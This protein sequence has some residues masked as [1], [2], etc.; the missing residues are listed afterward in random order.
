MAN[1]GRGGGISARLKT[2]LENV[3]EERSR[4][5]L[6]EEQVTV[7]VKNTTDATATPCQ[8]LNFCVC[9]EPGQSALFMHNNF[10]ALWK[11]FIRRPSRKKEDKGQGKGK[12]KG[13]D[14]KK[15]P[16]MP[17]PF[18]RKL[19]DGA[20]LVFC[21]RVHEP[22]SF[23]AQS[24]DVVWDSIAALIFHG[25]NDPGAAVV[26]HWV[27]VGYM[28]FS[29][30]RFCGC[31]LHRCEGPVAAAEEAK[32]GFIHLQLQEEDHDF[33]HCLEFFATLD[34]ELSWTVKAFQ[35]VSNT[36]T[37]ALMIPHFVEVVELKP[38][39]KECPE[40]ILFWK[41][42]HVES[43]LRKTKRAKQ[44]S[45]GPRRGGGGGG[46]AGRARA[47]VPGR[48]R[49]RGRSRG[50]AAPSVLALE[51]R[52]QDHDDQ[53]ADDDEPADDPLFVAEADSGDEDTSDSED[54]ELKIADLLIEH[55]IATG[56]VPLDEESKPKLASPGPSGQPAGNDEEEEPE[57]ASSSG[58]QAAASSS[59]A[60]PAASDDLA[61]RLR[62]APDPEDTRAPAASRKEVVSRL[63]RED[64]IT[65]PGYGEITYYS[66]SKTLVATCTNPSHQNER[67]CKK[68]KTVKASAAPG[69][70]GQGRPLGLLMSWVTT[71]EKHDDQWSHVHFGELE[72]TLAQRKSARAEFFKLR[73]AERF[74][75]YE[76]AQ[77]ANEE[78]EPN[79][80]P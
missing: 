46:R 62:A 14:G 70:M 79:Y 37:V 52:L 21:F 24:G 61:P 1:P 53:T 75:E 73:G 42:K 65:I 3:L 11:P 6:H 54:D 49:A 59:S 13:K 25:D 19:L 16:K 71:S 31:R 45:T 27:H 55:E 47:R 57:P 8:T 5:Y 41:G 50:N 9:K 26:E 60:V 78:E 22:T 32:T 2:N 23:Q 28:N 7:D 56:Q 58:R 72:C 40:G 17:K 15:L 33:F 48:G 12:G 35:I 66:T 34:C 67:V 39:H 63:P 29:T 38:E 4:M 44:Q 36:D 69:R 80:V 20:G 64:A 74:K 77:K 18:A 10:A 30:Y 76:R 43:S 68:S 51:D